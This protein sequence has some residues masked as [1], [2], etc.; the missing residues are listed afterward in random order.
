ML[1]CQEDDH[2]IYISLDMSFWICCNLWK[3]C[4][5][6]LAHLS[7]VFFSFFSR[8]LYFLAVVS[9]F[10]VFVFVSFVFPSV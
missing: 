6:L 4:Q 1:P 7:A 9:L 5:T 3:L 10:S 2:V 8:S